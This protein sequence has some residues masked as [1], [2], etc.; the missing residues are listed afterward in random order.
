MTR[1]ES[2]MVRIKQPHKELG[3]KCSGRGTSKRTDSKTGTSVAEDRARKKYREQRGEENSIRQGPER[4]Q[5]CIPLGM[6]I[7]QRIQSKQEM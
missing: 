5:D 6:E 1:A 3:E 4:R 7:Q 2:C